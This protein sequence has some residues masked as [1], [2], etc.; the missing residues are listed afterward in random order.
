[1][2]EPLPLVTVITP[3][4][5]R[6]DMLAETIESILAQEYPRVEY[7]VLDDGSQ[8]HT[9]E[10]LK[11]YEGR[12]TWVRHENMGQPR[13]VNRGFEMA[14]GELICTIN[15]DDPQPPGLLGPLVQALID[16]PEVDL[17]YPDWDMIDDDGKFVRTVLTLDCDFVD[18]ARWFLCDPGP[19]TLFRRKLLDAVGP[20][21]PAFRYCP[22]FDWLLRAGLV[23]RFRRVPQVRARWRHHSG[24][25]T[26][27]QRSEAMARDLVALA[28]KFYGRDDLP[29][30]I[31]E[32]RAEGYRNALI[33]AGLLVADDP[34]PDTRFQ[35]RD[36]I[37]LRHN[38]PAIRKPESKSPQATIFW[39]HQEVA[40]RDKEVERLHREVAIRDE[41]VRRLRTVIGDRLTQ[42]EEATLER[43]GRSLRARIG[44]LLRRAGITLPRAR[45]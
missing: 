23:A 29:R 34:G 20:W 22:D 11:R 1:M 19:G 7:I 44:Q 9:V 42:R 39:L 26:A 41:E 12:L 28:E 5:N 32:V 45:P 21:D 35:V 3:T 43:T 16:E 25:I 36:Q 14:T 15:S 17:V 8:D 31:L 37:D 38:E 24:S 6:A 33:T 40:L 2:A 27:G 13:T 30:E 10:V 18:L 4:F